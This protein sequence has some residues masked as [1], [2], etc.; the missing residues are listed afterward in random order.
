MSNNGDVEYECMNTNKY[1]DAFTNNY[2]KAK[3]NNPLAGC[4]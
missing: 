4:Q 3:C 2:G 1:M